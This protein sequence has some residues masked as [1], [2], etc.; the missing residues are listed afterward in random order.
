MTTLPSEVLRTKPELNTIYE[1]KMLE[2]VELMDQRLNGDSHEECISRAW[3]VLGILIGGFTMARAVAYQC[4]RS[5][6]TFYNKYS[7]QRC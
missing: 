1:E 3:A 6:C 4:C 5:Y 2:I 7:N